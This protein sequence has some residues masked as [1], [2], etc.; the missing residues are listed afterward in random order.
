MNEGEELKKEI[1]KKY[2]KMELACQ[3]LSISKPTL[4]SYFKM[5]RISTTI[6][7][8]IE[9][10]TGIIIRKQSTR[11]RYSL[12]EKIEK[13]EMEVSELK[14]QIIRLLNKS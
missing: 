14:S 4:Y 5:E 11:N 8:E 3:D 1:R 6:L 10:K 13:L 7:E 9:E 2:S 12:E